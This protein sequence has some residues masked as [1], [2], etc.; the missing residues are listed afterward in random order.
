MT[1]I[2]VFAACLLTLA[3]TASATDQSTT[4]LARVTVVG[5]TTGPAIW[6]LQRGDKTLWILGTLHPVPKDIRVDTTEIEARIAQS[7]VV[8][9]PSGIAIGEDMGVF[10]MLFLFPAA[11]KA[12]NNPDGKTLRDVLP[13]DIHARWTAAKQ[14]FLGRGDGIERRRPLYAAFELYAAALKQSGLTPSIP[15][16]S[17]RLAS[18]NDIPYRDARLHVAV[19]GPRKAIKQFAAATLPDTQCLVETLDRLDADLARMRPRAEA[20]AHGDVARL[21]QL[22]YHEQMDTCMQAL[23]SNAT[24]QQHG[25]ADMTNQ[26]RT[27]WLAE[28][29]NALRDHDRVFSSL[30]IRVLLDADGPLRALEAEGFVVRVPHDAA[31]V[32]R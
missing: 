12:Q 18:R 8:L 4:Q 6:E 24:I 7:Q 21:A 2:A 22:R 15:N 16:P 28:T 14:K 11:S 23:G 27:R 9:G 1:R 5:K 20:W 19:E 13:A 25:M 32:E 26:M 29:R 3:A 10:K 17:A 31:L 30:P